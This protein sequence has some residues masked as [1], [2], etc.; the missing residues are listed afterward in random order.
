M[1]VVN[2]NKYGITSA[3]SQFDTFL[4]SA[5]EVRCHQPCEPTYAVVGMYHI[6]TYLQLID[7]FESDDGFASSG[8]LRTK[9]DAVVAFEYL[10]IGIAAYFCT[11]I[12]KQK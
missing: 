10:M 11:F 2:T 3:V 6:I 9:A 1:Q 7:F 4:T 8:I 5:V 12:H